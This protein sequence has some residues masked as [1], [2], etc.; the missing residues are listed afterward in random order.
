MVVGVGRSGTTLLQSLLASSPRIKSSPETGAY[1]RLLA[2]KVFSDNV[3]K[4][5]LEH[6]C[7]A[8]LADPKVARLGIDPLVFR[9]QVAQSNEP[10]RI[11]AYRALI[12]QLR[13]EDRVFCDKDPRSVEIASEFLRDF[14]EG[15]IVHIFRDP[16]AVIASK[17]QALWAMSDPLLVMILKGR[18]QLLFAEK[19]KS[20]FPNRY[21]E[22]K[23]ED[24]IVDSE[25]TLQQV[26]R[27]LGGLVRIEN[28]DHLR[29]AEQL[30]IIESEP[31]KDSVTKPLDQEK[32]S[33]WRESLSQH[34]AHLIEACFRGFLSKNGYL[35]SPRHCKHAAL[36]PL[37]QLIGSFI[38]ILAQ[39]YVSLCYFKSNVSMKN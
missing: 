10:Y 36:Q 37:Y 22:I 18:I 1:R 28:L 34:E 11:S 19:A 26:E 25:K 27:V 4:Q 32:V 3:R 21:I 8:F 24:L 15:A 2:S 31:W 38:S 16:R 12:T 30:I 9:R 17:K 33:E 14:P 5:G 23:Y 6:A 35:L 39:S 7:E 20:L 29:V 13:G